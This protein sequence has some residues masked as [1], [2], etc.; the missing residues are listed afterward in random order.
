MEAGYS[1]NVR[2]PSDTLTDGFRTFP[3]YGGSIAA[4]DNLTVVIIEY[5]GHTWRI[6]KV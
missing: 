1:I 2:I 4:P 5:A 3:F 6:P